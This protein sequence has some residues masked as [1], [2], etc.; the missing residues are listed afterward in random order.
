VDAHGGRTGGGGEYCFF[1]IHVSISFL[2]PDLTV[3]VETYQ[4]RP[5]YPPEKE[6]KKFYALKSV[7]LEGCV[8]LLK[9][10]SLTEFFKTWI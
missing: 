7:F 3:S 2:D 1:N 5:K 10:K 4:R 9:H 8:L 6:K